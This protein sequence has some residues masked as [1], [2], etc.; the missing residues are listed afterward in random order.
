MSL[1]VLVPIREVNRG[2]G[3]VSHLWRCVCLLRSPSDPVFDWFA[4]SYVRKVRDGLEIRFLEDVWASTSPLCVS[5]ERLF[6]IS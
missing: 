6:L 1:K 3:N 2:L 5:F 4:T